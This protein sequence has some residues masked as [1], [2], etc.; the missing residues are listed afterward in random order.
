MARIIAKSGRD[1]PL[2]VLQIM[3]IERFTALPQIP[4]M[5]ISSSWT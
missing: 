5:P 2:I 1:R 3:N 4:V